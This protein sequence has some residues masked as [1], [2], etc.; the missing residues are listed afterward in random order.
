MNEKE[1]LA[2]NSTTLR[3]RTKLTGCS[4]IQISMRINGSV[5]IFKIKVGGHESVFET[6]GKSE[7]S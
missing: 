6:F 4:V 2:S 5:S 7:D 3:F 1:F